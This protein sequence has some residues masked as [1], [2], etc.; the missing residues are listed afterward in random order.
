MELK[1]AYYRIEECYNRMR[2]VGTTSGRKYN[3][4]IICDVMDS[5]PEVCNYWELRN[6][7]FY[8]DRVIKIRTYVE[9]KKPRNNAK[10]IKIIT[11]AEA[12]A[13]IISLE[14]CGQLKVGKTKNYD[15]RMYRLEKQYGEITPMITFDFDNEEDAYLMEVILHKFFKERYPESTFVPQDRFDYIPISSRDVDILE[16]VAEKIRKEIWF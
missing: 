2:S 3:Y 7:R 1:E 6:A 15:E 8:D 5:C 11:S 14:D 12:C 16:K 10:E 13:Y 9:P 4:N